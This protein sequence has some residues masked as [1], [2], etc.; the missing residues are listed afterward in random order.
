MMVN[1]KT[2][3]SAFS[4]IIYICMN[5]SQH[6][7]FINIYMLL[8]IYNLPV[9]ICR[10]TFKFCVLHESA[11]TIYLIFMYGSKF[12]FLC[13]YNSLNFYMWVNIYNLYLFS[14]R[15]WAGGSVFGWS[16]MI[17]AGR[18]RIRFPIK[19]KDFLIYLIIPVSLWPWG[20]LIP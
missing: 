19:S 16:T 6:L 4:S 18:P 13:I 8:N 14:C 10:S 1:F 15:L 9:F 12:T 2:L 20:W 7:K 5:A 17:Q 11:F 3:I